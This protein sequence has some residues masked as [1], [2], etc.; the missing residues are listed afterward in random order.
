M[1][2]GPIISVVIPTFNRKAALLA[3]LSSLQSQDLR[4]FECVV[5]DNGPSTDGT[6]EA[7]VEIAAKDSRFSLAQ[8]VETGPFAAAAVGIERTH[9][10]LVFLMDDDVELVNHTTLSDIA[11]VFGSDPTL[12]VLGISEF[13]PG[14]RHR[15]GEAADR[16]ASGISIWLQDTR[17]YSPGR[18]SKWGM[19]GTKFHRLPFGQL[20]EVDH[21]RS[22]AM[23]VRRC[24]YESGGGFLASYSGSGNGY[25]CETD[26]CLQVRRAGFK[27]M[28]S[29]REPQVLHKQA[30]RPDGSVR[31]GFGRD[32]LLGT[33]RNNT[34]FFLR[35][36]W[37]RPT[38]PV[39]LAWDMLIGSSSQPGILR[40][41]KARQWKVRTYFYAMT[42]KWRGMKQFW[43]Y[44]P[45]NTR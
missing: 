5:V 20:H 43:R 45:V 16:H 32:F 14:D 29:A 37:T 19:I 30:A 36:F 12:G 34:Y 18:I 6:V 35:N 15:G 2:A 42:G 28:F 40:L 13:Y 3:A 44:G 24:A 11:N 31:G 21:V 23:V 33:G 10:A 22:S 8:S 7:V 1:R 41:L 38:S 27:V 26:L 17:L 39:F 9:A 25:R 4:L